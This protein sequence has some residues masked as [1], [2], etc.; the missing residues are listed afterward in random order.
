MPKNPGILSFYVHFEH[1]IRIFYLHLYTLIHQLFG[2]ENIKGV[3]RILFHFMLCP[4]L[5]SYPGYISLEES[6]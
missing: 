1:F 2:Y 3:T 4:L 6:G 5:L